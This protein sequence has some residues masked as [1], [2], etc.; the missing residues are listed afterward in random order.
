MITIANF[1]KMAYIFIYKEPM[2]RQFLQKLE[3][4]YICSIFFSP[5]LVATEKKWLTQRIMKRMFTGLWA[6]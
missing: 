4:A 5:N 3:I 6:K 2:A 1:F